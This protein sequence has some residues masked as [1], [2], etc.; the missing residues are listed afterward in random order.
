MIHPDNELQEE[1]DAED[2]D[3]MEPEYQDEDDQ[4]EDES[5]RV[6]DP[7]EFRLL[8][9]LEEKEREIGRAEDSKKMAM[10]EHNDGIKVLKNH[11]DGLL[12]ALQ[13]YRS[14]QRGLPLE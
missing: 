3:G 11:R 6:V 9:L 5:Y 4:A 10:D 12:D 7:E 14:G 13:S 8:L 2:F 1:I